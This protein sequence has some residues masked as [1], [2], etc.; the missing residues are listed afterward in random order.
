VQSQTGER[1]AD[2]PLE[3][4][5]FASVFAR[6]VTAARSE[7]ES[8]I[9]SIGCF[10]DTEVVTAVDLTLMSAAYFA[11]E[12]PRAQLHLPSARKCHLAAFFCE[13]IRHRAAESLARRHDGYTP[14]QSEVHSFRSYARVPRRR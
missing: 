4:N 7:F 5:S 12:A 10:T 8:S 3:P 6:P 2:L 9:P 11:R 1:T 14:F 13:L